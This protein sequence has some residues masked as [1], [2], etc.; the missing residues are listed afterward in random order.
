MA[1]NKFLRINDVMDITRLAKS[2][3]FPRVK[4]KKLLKLIRLLVPLTIWKQYVF[5]LII[6]HI[7]QVII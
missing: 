2:T 6:T 5:E 7:E 1:K 4:Q 3:V